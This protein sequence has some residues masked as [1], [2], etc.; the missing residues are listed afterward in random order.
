MYVC[1]FKCKKCAKKREEHFLSFLPYRSIAMTSRLTGLYIKYKRTIAM[2]EGYKKWGR[3]ASYRFFTLAD[4]YPFR[5]YT[6]YI[7]CDGTELNR[8]VYI[9]YHVSLWLTLISQVISKMIT[10]NLIQKLAFG[11]LFLWDLYVILVRF[12]W[13]FMSI[14]YK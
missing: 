1:A 4:S 13:N 2:V 3:K 7:L 12:W 8:I 10:G 6:S 11:R 14:L 5:S 9:Q